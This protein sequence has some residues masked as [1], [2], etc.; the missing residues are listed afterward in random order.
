MASIAVRFEASF[1]DRSRLFDAVEGTIFT[2]YSRLAPL[3]DRFNGQHIVSQGQTGS[4]ADRPAGC[5][6][7]GA[8]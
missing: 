1:V 8:R 5:F 2:V 4:R 7:L 6:A 3:G